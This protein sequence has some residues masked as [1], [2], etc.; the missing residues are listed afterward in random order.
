MKMSVA[1]SSVNGSRT[2][3]MSRRVPYSRM[4]PFGRI[5]PG[6]ASNTTDPSCR[7]STRGSSRGPLAVSP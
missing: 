7:A 4:N 1:S 5:V 6:N 2:C 3:A